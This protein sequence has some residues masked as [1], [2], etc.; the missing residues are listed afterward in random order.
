MLLKNAVVLIWIL[1]IG[2]ASLLSVFLLRTRLSPLRIASLSLFISVGILATLI[3]FVFG[4]Y[5]PPPEDGVLTFA[6]APLIVSVFLVG[7]FMAWAIGANDTANSLGTAIGSRVLTLRGALIRIA[8]FDLLGA[9]LFGTYVT[10]TIGKGIVDTS[11][12]AE[13]DVIF[14]GALSAL[15]AA[16]IWVAFATWRGLPVSTTHSIVGGML[17]FG[18]VTSAAGS[19]IKWEVMLKIVLSW[20]TSPVCG[21]VFAFLLF[22]GIKKFVIGRAKDVEKVEKVFGYFQIC[23]AM[24]VGFSFGAN[25]VANAIGPIYLVLSYYPGEI[26]LPPLLLLLFGAGGIIVGAFTWGRKIIKTV[27]YRITRIS[28]SSGF[29]AEFSTAS[30]ILVASYFGMPISTTHT[31]V[32]SVVGIG[33]AGGLEAVDLRVVRNIIYSWLIT[34][35]VAMGVAAILYISIGGI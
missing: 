26:M 25:D 14:L 32:G 9:T 33:L 29:S 34:P 12:I 17:G 5:H 2:V 1:G 35:V 7:G 20:V 6:F 4:V 16:G 10:H 30:I 13:T 22:L 23:T 27:G 11:G 31:I 3:F 28:P 24:Y 18:L 8:I 21:V 19:V 15:L